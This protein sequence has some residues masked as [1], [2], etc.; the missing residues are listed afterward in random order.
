M[1]KSTCFSLESGGLKSKQTEI[2]GVWH[3]K[4]SS[5]WGPWRPSR[6]Y[7][8]RDAVHKAL[9]LLK[10]FLSSLSRFMAPKS[11]RNLRTSETKSQIE[12]SILKEMLKY[13]KDIH[14]LRI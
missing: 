13:C 12:C 3:V 11:L 5:W 7:P 10:Y 2:D 1:Q 4:G 14:K 6:S 8:V 9:R